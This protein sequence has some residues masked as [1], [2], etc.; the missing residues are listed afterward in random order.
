MLGNNQEKMSEKSIF[1]VTIEGTTN[2]LNQMK[3][4][5][6]K[7]YK[8][9]GKYGSGFF[10]QIFPKTNNYKTFLITSN[11]VINENS[12]NKDKKIQLTLKDGQTNIEL[13]I[14]ESRKT[15][16]SKSSG[17]TIIEIKNTDNINYFLELDNSIFNSAALG[18]KSNSI[19]NISY[20]NNQKVSVSYGN[21]KGFKGI[22]IYHNC[23]TDSVSPGSPLLNLHNNKV[24][25][26]HLGTNKNNI[27]IGIL[28]N[29]YIK[30]YLSFFNDFNSNPP[31]KRT[32][33]KEIPE[34]QISNKNPPF[35]RSISHPIGQSNYSLIPSSSVNNSSKLAKTNIIEIKLYASKDDIKNKIYFLNKSK[36]FNEDNIEIYYNNEKTKKF[37]SYIRPEQEGL[38]SIK[39]LFKENITDCME[40]FQDCKNITSIDLSNLKTENVKDMSYMFNNCSNLTTINLSSFETLNVN[41]MKNMFCFCTKLTQ[42]I[43]LSSFNTSN[44]VDMHEMFF[45]CESLASLNLSSFDFT[46]VKDKRFMLFKCKS[47]KRLIIKAI[48]SDGVKKECNYK[49]DEIKCI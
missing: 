26:L 46:N 29:D 24:I 40:M 9:D 25:G 42:I 6:C 33:T 43:G 18:F 34:S 2:I 41:R 45:G 22:T 4:A 28:I 27:N 23:S 49:I 35:M 5:I 3:C 14:D 12:I 32:Q 20:Q 7:I 48:F 47:L 10:C 17:V 39:L 11:Y 36:K 1:P 13:N 38:H 16:F 8:G 31:F 37:K 30:K 19:Y 15:Y 44:V 21:L